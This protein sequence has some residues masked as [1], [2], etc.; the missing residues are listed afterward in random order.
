MRVAQLDENDVLLS[1]FN[2][3]QSKRTLAEEEEAKNERSLGW[4]KRR[5]KRRERVY[6]N[7]TR[8][9]RERRQRSVRATR[10]LDDDITSLSLFPLTE[11]S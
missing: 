7:R 1:V 2:S 10:N 8:E 6:A 11:T 5:E 3:G 4:P 9:E